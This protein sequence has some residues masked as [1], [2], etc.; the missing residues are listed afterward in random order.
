MVALSS[1]ASAASVSVNLR[2][3]GIRVLQMLIVSV[4]L[5]HPG[6]SGDVPPGQRMVPCYASQAVVVQVGGEERQRRPLT[7]VDRAAVA[8]LGALEVR[9]RWCRLA[10]G[11]GY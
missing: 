7:F 10:V 1:R 3:V 8:E 9:P 6:S 11:H 2:G 4:K 5:I